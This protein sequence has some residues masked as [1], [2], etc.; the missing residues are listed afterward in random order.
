MTIWLDP[1]VA[2]RPTLAGPVKRD[3]Y[4]LMG[5]PASALATSTRLEDHESLEAGGVL[6]A[7][8]WKWK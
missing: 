2:P 6:V 1:G 8:E 3:W 4:A 7:E 5:A